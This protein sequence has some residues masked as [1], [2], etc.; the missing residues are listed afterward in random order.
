MF[1]PKDYVNREVNR[2]L[3]QIA[4]IFSVT[5][6]FSVNCTFKLSLK[7]NSKS[8]TETRE[9]ARQ[10]QNHFHNPINSCVAACMTWIQ[11]EHILNLVSWILT[12]FPFYMHN[13][14][15][16]TNNNNKIY[17]FICVY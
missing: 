9:A 7:N 14:L 5:I 12:A 11:V 10:Q 17:L 16:N 8:K 4:G 6:L 1:N 15:T 3:R 2:F 13:K